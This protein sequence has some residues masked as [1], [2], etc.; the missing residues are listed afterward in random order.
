MSLNAFLEQV[1]EMKQSRHV[2]DDEL[3]NSAYDLF[4]EV[5]LIWYR[6]NKKKA[7]DWPS[8]VKL[9]REEFLPKNYNDRLFKQIKERT[10][11][12]DEPMGIYIAFMNNHFERLTIKVP[13]SSRI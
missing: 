7:T 13:E 8:L 6:G 1:D 3:F 9:L 5:A 10:Q 4:S 11:H 12:P 2:S